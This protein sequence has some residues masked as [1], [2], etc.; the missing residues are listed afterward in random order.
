MDTSQA[1]LGVV[2]TLFSQ[3]PWETV[4]R[5]RPGGIATLRSE[6]GGAGRKQVKETERHM[7]SRREGGHRLT[8]YRTEKIKQERNLSVHSLGIGSNE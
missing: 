5:L 8:P 6:N 2:M 4:G 1:E 7:L 3:R